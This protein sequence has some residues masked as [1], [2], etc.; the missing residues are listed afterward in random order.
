ME[1]QFAPVGVGQLRERGSSP[2]RAR[3]SFRWRRSL[4][5][6]ALRH[7]RRRNSSVNCLSRTCLNSIRRLNTRRSDDPKTE[8][9]HGADVDRLAD[10][11][12]RRDR[13]VD[14]A[15][16]DP[17]HLGASIDAARV[18]RQRV[19]AEFCGAAD[20]R[21]R[22]LATGSDAGGCSPP[23]WRCSPPP[24]RP[25]PCRRHRLADRRARRPGRRRGADRATVAGAAEGGV[26]ARASRLGAGDLRRD[27][28]LAVLAGPVVGGAVTQG[29][30]WQWIFWLNVPIGLAAI[31]L[32][33]TR[34][35]RAAARGRRSMS[36][37]WPW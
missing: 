14:R 13:R 11:G 6:Y 21:R 29:L 10:G 30:D 7:H 24:R 32:V 33:L 4:S 3:L 12:A 18:D 31:P 37:A 15:D 25:A 5:S 8:M 9:G 17:A 1:L 22:R 27:H 34:M 19:R 16:D 36:P 28:G 20:D 23:A 26:P 35:R 2:A